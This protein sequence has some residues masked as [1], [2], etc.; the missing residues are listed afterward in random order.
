MNKKILA[1]EIRNLADKI[2]A[3][4]PFNMNEIELQLYHNYDKLHDILLG[5]KEEINK[6]FDEENTDRD[7]MVLQNILDDFDEDMRKLPRST[8]NFYSYLVQADSVISSIYDSVQKN[9]LETL[10]ELKADLDLL[11]GKVYAERQ[12]I[13]QK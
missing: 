12:K 7:P 9:D 1:N 10:T 2:L 13:R 5:V 4:S 11:A 6:Y 8:D 3:S